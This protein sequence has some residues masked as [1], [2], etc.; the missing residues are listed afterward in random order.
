VQERERAIAFV[1][2]LAERSSA[3]LEGGSY[4]AIDRSP[5]LIAAAAQ[6]DTRC[7][8]AEAC[9]GARAERLGGRRFDVVFVV[10]VGLIHRE[11]ERERALI[12]PLQALGARV[13]AGFERPS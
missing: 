9:D 12:A 3:R 2:L 4:S 10:R 5:K 1:S 6:R 8:F 11:P 7:S 13:H